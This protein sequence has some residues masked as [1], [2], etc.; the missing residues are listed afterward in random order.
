MFTY[1]LET[2]R[3]KDGIS[4]RHRPE[5]IQPEK[6]AGRTEFVCVHVCADVC[7]GEC[8]CTLRD[9]LEM[10]ESA[11]KMGLGLGSR[12]TAVERGPDTCIFINILLN[13]GFLSRS[14]SP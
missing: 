1:F 6:N 8:P 7:M 5:L 2:N 9:L 10:G 3:R 11:Y 13:S 12:S 4:A 14:Q